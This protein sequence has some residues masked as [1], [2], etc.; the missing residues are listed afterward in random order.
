[1]LFQ[2]KIIS[3]K[4]PICCSVALVQLAHSDG[5]TD[6]TAL[7]HTHKHT[8]W[9]EG[10]WEETSIRLHKL[11]INSSKDVRRIHHVTWHTCTKTAAPQQQT[12]KR[13]PPKKKHKKQRYHCD[14]Q[15]TLLVFCL[16]FSLSP[17][18]FNAL[19]FRILRKALTACWWHLA[20][21]NIFLQRSAWWGFW[22]RNVTLW[23]HRLSRFGEAGQVVFLLSELHRLTVHLLPPSHKPS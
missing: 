17:L 18:L 20:S 10:G 1:M 5:S 8:W 12:N 4:K 15:A 6:I 16:C 13:S 7:Q 14:T 9:M 3:R 19:F 11:Y 2:E 21:A 22:W 23:F